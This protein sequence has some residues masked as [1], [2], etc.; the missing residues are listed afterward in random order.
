MGLNSKIEWTDHTWNP[1]YGCHKV[2]EGCRNCY[3]YRERSQY[4]HDPS[5]VQRSKTT[6]RDP[7]IWAKAARRRVERYRIFACSWS[8]FFIEESDAWRTDAW[9]II[10]Q[11]PELI[12]LILTKRPDRIRQCLPEGWF[13]RNVWW[14]VSIESNEYLYR[15]D[16][17]DSELHY[18][19]PP[20]LFVSLEPLLSM[21]DLS[22]IFF[23]IDI[24]DEDRPWQTRSPDWVIVG[25]ESGTQ[26]RICHP[27][28]VRAIRDQ[29]MTANAPFFFK[30]WGEY[31]P[32][33]P[34]PEQRSVIDVEYEKVGRKQSGAVLDGREWREFPATE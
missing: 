9:E 34:A 11:T 10:Q 26:A 31:L 33:E 32:M 29:C 24:G 18:H 19:N 2:S 23:E 16:I 4:G 3:M 6:F 17:L 20:V 14:G 21:I 12:Y 7:L 8:D 22:T 15:W 27:D 5:K 30:Q 25:G 13:P 28:W 1:W